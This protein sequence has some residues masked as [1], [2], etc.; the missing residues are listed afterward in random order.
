MIVVEFIVLHFFSSFILDSL[1]SSE[2]VG[3]LEQ[4]LD[5]VVVIVVVVI[6]RIVN[7]L[8]IMINHQPVV[9][10]SL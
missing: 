8:M 1:Q 10:Y 2:L 7:S 5:C 6:E 9:H 3:R 4:L